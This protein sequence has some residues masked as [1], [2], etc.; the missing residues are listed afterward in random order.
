MLR[1]T[2][3]HCGSKET[4]FQQFEFAAKPIKKF[5]AGKRRF[6]WWS[7]GLPDGIFSNKKIHVWV[8]FGGSCNGRCWYIGLLYIHLVYFVAIW[9]IFWFFGMFPPRFGKLYKEKS[10]NPDDGP[11][12]EHLRNPFGAPKQDHSNLIRLSGVD[13]LDVFKCIRN[14][15]CLAYFSANIDR[16]CI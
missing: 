5:F 8:N 1:L 4:R 7:E 3:G 13:T 14:E 15:A 16:R 6:F 10:G 2:R 11:N 12:F 9:Y